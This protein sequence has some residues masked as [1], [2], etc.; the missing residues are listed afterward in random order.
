MKDESI[1]AV[2]PLSS[3][4]VTVEQIAPKKEALKQD[5]D[6]LL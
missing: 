3:Q 6:E 1:E 4:E 2:K 5:D